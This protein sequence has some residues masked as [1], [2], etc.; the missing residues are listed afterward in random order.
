MVSCGSIAD[1]TYPA[2]VKFIHDSTSSL[3]LPLKNFLISL[4]FICIQ[5]FADSINPYS[6][7]T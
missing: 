7:M 1:Q 3:S 4:H 6:Q 2:T 5:D